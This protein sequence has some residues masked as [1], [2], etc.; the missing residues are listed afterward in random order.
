MN[1]EFN[2]SGELN[3]LIF[4]T[5]IRPAAFLLPIECVL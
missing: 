2:F 1:V 4:S 5:T 3:S